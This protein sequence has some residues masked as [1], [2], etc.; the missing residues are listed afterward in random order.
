MVSGLS[1]TGADADVDAGEVK[2]EGG[3]GDWTGDATAKV[4]AIVPGVEG[5]NGMPKLAPK[6]VAMLLPKLAFSAVILLLA[7]SLC[8]FFFCLLRLFFCFLFLNVY[9]YLYIFLPFFLFFSFC[10]CVCCMCCVC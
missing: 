3:A 1:T 8:K 5:E 9:I 7:N 10:G 2:A 4:E 6:L